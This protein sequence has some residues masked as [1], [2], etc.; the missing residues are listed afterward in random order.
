MCVC[1]RNFGIIVDGIRTSAMVPYAD[2]LNHFR[3]RE[4]R[5]PNLSIAYNDLH[6]SLSL[7]TKW[8]YDGGRRAFTI[9]SLQ[10]IG[11]GQQVYDSYGQK[12]NHR[13]LLNYGFSIENNCEADGFC[14]NEVPFKFALDLQDELRDIKMSLWMRDGNPTKLVRISVSDNENTSFAL[15][16]LRVMVANREDFYNLSATGAL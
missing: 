9:T 10:P 14:P 7:Q 15:S 1:S 8:A 16:C 12:C 13:F 3:P 6:F 2:M 4:V 5:Y 11:S